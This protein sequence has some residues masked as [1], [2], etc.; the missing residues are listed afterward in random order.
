MSTTISVYKSKRNPDMY[1]YVQEKDNFSHVPDK[2]R[3]R[4]G[5]P[6]FVLE[7]DILQRT[8]LGRENL[9]VVIKN[10]KKHGYHLQ[11]PETI[12][13]SSMESQSH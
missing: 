1:L 2:L 6:I 8:H 7:F 3:E 10:L 12:Q 9:A 5:E 13:T 4:F 11:L